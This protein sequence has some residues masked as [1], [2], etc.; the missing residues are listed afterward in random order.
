M[1][2][3]TFLCSTCHFILFVLCMHASYAH[4]DI[5]WNIFFQICFL[6]ISMGD[7]LEA[8][9]SAIENIQEEFEH[10]IWEV[11]EHLAILTSLFEDYIKTQ[12]VLPWGPSP[13][14]NLQV[15]RPFVQTT[16]YLPRR[17]DCPNLRQPI[18][19]APPAFVATSRPANQ[20]SGSRDKLNRQ[21]IDKDKPWW[22]PIP[23]TY[24]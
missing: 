5:K 14:P 17:T 21:K 2:G 4:Q 18:P 22:D 12:A 24:T 23:I 6:G 16:S 7:R 1:I 13:L 8:W 19:T 9:I 3:Q 11:K 20:L 10:D 15:P